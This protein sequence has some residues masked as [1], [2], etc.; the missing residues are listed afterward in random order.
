M[1][2]RRSHKDEELGKTSR[3]L[4]WARIIYLASTTLSTAG[5]LMEGIFIRQ[6]LAPY[7]KE[8]IFQ[9]T[10][11]EN[12]CTKTISEF[13][14]LVVGVHYKLQDGRLAHAYLYDQLRTLNARKKRRCAIQPCHLRKEENILLV[15][16]FNRSLAKQKSFPCFFDSKD[17]RPA[18]IL[19]KLQHVT[20]VMH[21]LLWPAVVV[22]L[23]LLTIL[24][25]WRLV[26][27]SPW[28]KKEHF[29]V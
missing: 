19:Y 6:F 15:Q 28:E 14:C 2:V 24:F 8:S 25:T 1:I 26:G 12:K 22:C 18:V 13:P 20:T 23:C 21:S 9:A 27:C 17:T 16:A 10:R 4:F 7:I 29:I 11:C 5:I 3:Y